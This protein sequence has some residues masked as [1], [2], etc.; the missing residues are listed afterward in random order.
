L[1]AA[2]GEPGAVLTVSGLTT[3]FGGFAALAG[4]S[5]EVTG[6]EIVG[7]IGPNGSSKPTRFNCLAGA[8]PPTQGS[9]R[10]RG[11]ELA[12]LIPDTVCHRGIARTFQIP[13]PVRKRTVLENRAVAAL[14]A[15]LYAQYI[16]YANPDTRAGIDVSLRSWSRPCA[17]ACIRCSALRP[18][19]H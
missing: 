1:V 8:L 18:D 6:G 12:G 4:I 10:V 16:S 17:A 19:R 15:V 9:I 2:R 5:F 11:A 7:L 14:G 3:R 13:R